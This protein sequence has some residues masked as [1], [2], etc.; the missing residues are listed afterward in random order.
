MGKFIQGFLVTWLIGWGAMGLF[1]SLSGN[2][3]W[4]FAGIV[5]GILALLAAIKVS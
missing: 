1:L 3:A 2:P 5:S 4:G